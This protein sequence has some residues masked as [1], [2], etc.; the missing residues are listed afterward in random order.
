MTKGVLIVNGYMRTEK[1]EEITRL[2]KV[3]SEKVKIT[4]EVWYTDEI[5][6]GFQIDHSPFINKSIK[7]ISFVLF[8]DKDIMLARQL[9]RLGL[10]V[11][12]SA[13]AIEVC[14]NKAMTL[15][16]LVGSGIACPI[17]RI[18]PLVFKGMY[19]GDK[20]DAYI[21]QLESE[22]GYPMVI[23]ECYGSFGMQV[24]LARNRQELI[25]IRKKVIDVPH[26]YQA[27]ICTSIGRD[28]RI[29]VV[30]GKVVASMM[31]CNQED[32][33]ANITNG[34]QMYHYEPSEAFKEMAC[35]VCRQLGLD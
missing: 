4:L 22:L 1:F 3:A 6:Y 25:A 20:E 5:V 31:R 24:Y 14:D 35:Q 11:F 18:A 9:E 12:N 30:G 32:F 16:S 33:R 19:E 21:S 28:V 2:Y 29:H 34:G 26:L 15:E 7:D 13:H 8:L 23:K 10:R 27:F 17:T